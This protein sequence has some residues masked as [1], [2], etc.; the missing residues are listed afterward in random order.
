MNDSRKDLIHSISV[1]NMC[2]RTTGALENYNDVLGQRI[3][4]NFFK[5]VK[6]LI[7]EEFSHCRLFYTRSSVYGCFYK[8]TD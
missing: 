7:E 2:A 6:A 5:F 1:F 8:M 3:R 4:G